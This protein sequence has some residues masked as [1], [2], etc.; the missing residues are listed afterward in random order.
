MKRAMKNKIRPS[1]TSIT[2]AALLFGFMTAPAAQAETFAFTSSPLTNLNPAG[3]TINGG[4]TKFPAGK[5]LYIQQCNEPLAGARPTICSDTVQVW[6]SDSGARGTVKST[7][8]IIIKPTV[9]IT[10]QG[11]SAD[12]SKVSCG[13]FFQVDHVNNA[14]LSDR[15]EDKFLPITFASGVAAPALALDLFTVTAD[16]QTLTKNVGS[17]IFYRK[18]VTI[19]VTTQSGL[20]PAIISETADCTYAAGVFTALKGS[21]VCAITISTAGN[22]SFAAT[23]A[24]YPFFV[25]LGEQSIATIA[26]SVKVGKRLTLPVE[27][28]FGEKIVYKTSSKN[29]QVSKGVLKGIK[30]GSCVVTATAAGK[31]NLWKPL[32]RNISIPVK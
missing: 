14:S 6:V 12:C 1:L 27:T 15:S 9:A 32:V 20:T 5:G 21:G 19:L 31:V 13:L 22:A 23:D 28:S 17:N 8:G 18:P 7:S 4:F 24:N 10:G 16:G 25:G 3:A 30:K 29:C 2:I 26:A 11:G